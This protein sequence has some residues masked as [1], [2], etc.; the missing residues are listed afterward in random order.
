MTF[1]VLIACSANV[2]RSPLAAAALVRAVALEEVGRLIVVDTGG[3]DVLP[4]E[5][6]CPDLVRLA[7]SH[8][9]RSHDLIEHRARALTHDQVDVADIVLTADRRVR[10]GVLKRVPGAAPRTFTLREAA[11]LGSEAGREVQGRSVEER[12]RSYVAAMNATRGLTDLPRTRHV[13]AL[14]TPWRRMAV[15]AHDVPDAHQGEHA[16]H[17]TVFQLTTTGAEEVARGLT[18]C[19]PA[20]RT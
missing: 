19:V 16:P 14:T 6:T 17:R 11:Q 9:F 2:C 20:L 5:P 7:D 1:T 4:G 8:R 3:I 13:M 12:L 18:T 15:H 10:S